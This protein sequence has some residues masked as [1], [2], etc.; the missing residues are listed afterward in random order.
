MSKRIIVNCRICKS[1]LHTTEKHKEYIKKY[2]QRPDIIAKKTTCKNCFPDCKNN[3]I[4]FAEILCLN[5]NTRTEEW[6]H[7]KNGKV[8]LNNCSC[9][10]KKPESKDLKK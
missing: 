2:N 4:I 5:R 10:C 6:I 7:T 8:K 3:K 1:F 9:G